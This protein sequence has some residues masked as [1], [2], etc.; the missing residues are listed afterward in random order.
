VQLEEQ[1]NQELRDAEAQLMRLIE[2]GEGRLSEL[3][4]RLADLEQALSW[5]R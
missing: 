2:A 4:A 1:R 5:V 3:N